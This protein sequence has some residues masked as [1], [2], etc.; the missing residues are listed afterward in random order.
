MRMESIAYEL[1][2][3]LV[4]E[5][6]L[7]SEVYFTT[8]VIFQYVRETVIDIFQVHAEIFDIYVCL[9]QW[10]VLSSVH[11]HKGMRAKA[12]IDRNNQH[13]DVILPCD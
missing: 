7:C 9:W 12:H 13:Q 6:K 1:F 11:W 10:R 2:T 8:Y 5:L 3:F 4:M